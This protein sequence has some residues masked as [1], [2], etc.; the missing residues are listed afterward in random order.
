MIKRTHLFPA[1]A[2]GQMDQGDL[3]WAMVQAGPLSGPGVGL[4]LPQNLYPSELSNA[5]YDYPTN[6]IAL[7]A[8]DQIPIPRGDW[9]IGLGSYCCLQYFDPVNAI[10]EIVA[11]AA[12]DSGLLYLQSDGFNYRIAN[13]TGCPVGG[14]VNAY[15]SGYVQAST[16][17][18]VT[19]GGGSL[20][21][22]I[23]GGQLVMTTS[24][25]VTANAGAGYGVAPI[26]MLPSPPGPNNNV[27]GVGGVQA[28][29]YCTIAS[30]TVSG[31]T[32]TNP[33]A[34]YPTGTYTIQCLP[35]PTDPNITT[36]ITLAT[37]VFS[38]TGSGSICGV[39]CSNPGA[40]L[41]TP[42]N[43]TLTLSG[44]GTNGTVSAIMQQTVLSVSVTGTSTITSGGSGTVLL[45]SAGGY[46]LSA[47]PATPVT[48]TITNAPVYLVAGS[49]S[50]GATNLGLWA[51]PRPLQAL[52][53]SNTIAA[54]A[55]V[56]IIYDG[57]LFYSP[58][59]PV[60]AQG[61]IFTAAAGSI[62][63]GSTITLTM[64]PR[65]DFVVMQPLRA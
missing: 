61:G 7:A 22:P 18:A 51:R 19:G 56:G 2:S 34:G 63:G 10:W 49:V 64:G 27:N 59:A 44:A 60:I 46:P 5:P 43:I 23:V 28:S 36:G 3:S 42:N 6:Q 1:P 21:T 4:Q 65:P 58:P 26:A 35:N 32:F 16:T 37:L 40:P 25:V 50:A 55:G 30:G 38:V 24:T 31:F 39:L 57:G 52:F 11:T 17:I 45:T 9:L 29:G 33:G 62:I 53:T 8:G 48:G 14:I 15:G 47:G 41:S 20:W 54:G 12:W 13:L